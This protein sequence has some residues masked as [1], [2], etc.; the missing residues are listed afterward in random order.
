[1]DKYI[2]IKELLDKNKLSLRQR[3]R[4]VKLVDKEIQ[5]DGIKGSELEERV[6]KLEEK[7][8]IQIP[9]NADEEPYDNNTFIPKQ[10]YNPKDLYHFLRNYNDD[11]I[12]KSTCHRIDRKEIETIEKLC[13]IEKYKFQSHYEKIIEHYEELKKKYKKKFVDD[14]FRALIERYL[15]GGGNWN[16][17]I[18]YNWNSP[19]LFEWV[20]QNPGI[21]PNLDPSLFDEK[22]IGFEVNEFGPKIKL[23]P[24]TKIQ[25]FGDLVQYFKYLFHIRSDNS[26]VK[27]CTEI[28]KR[29]SAEIDFDY[30]AI[31]E[32]I[33][34]FTNVEKL[35][36][37]YEDLI[38]LVLEVKEKNGLD[39]PKIKLKFYTE[40]KSTIVFS[41]HHL[42][43]IYK[44]T[45]EDAVDR[46]GQ[47][48]K[49]LITNQL[50]GLCEFYINADFGNDKFAK[51]TIW[52]FQVWKEKK[53]NYSKSEKVEGVEYILKFKK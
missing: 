37:T 20:Q 25:T 52:N 2:F 31:N 12:L 8:G 16:Y 40:D 24:N 14:K 28:N 7:V 35:L 44:H 17:N 3:E 34:L 15:K 41:I 5:K 43:S 21:P 1:M 19:E 6:K 27:L 4:M 36:N 39:K 30:S 9:T 13:N 46:P 18:K 49:N 11:E 26:L 38:R 29:F 23:L 10:Y 32:A 33:E 51:L 47:T 48:Y 45:V 53:L 22:N 50:N 42:N